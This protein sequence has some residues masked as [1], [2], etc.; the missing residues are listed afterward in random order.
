MQFPLL[1]KWYMVYVKPTLLIYSFTPFLLVIDI[2]NMTVNLT[3]D[4]IQLPTFFNLH[5]FVCIRVH[6]YAIQ[7]HTQICE[8]NSKLGAELCHHYKG[9]L[10]RCPFLGTRTNHPTFC[11]FPL[12]TT[13]PS[14]MSVV[15]SFQE[16]YIETSLVVQWVRLHASNTGGK[17]LI[18]GWGTM[19]PHA[20]WHGQ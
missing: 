17:G 5:S 15:F 12:A 10:W 8:P 7:S 19:I 11:P 2:G 4:L 3:T 16:W 1:Y 14:S 13:H 9:S 18:P 20:A 6:F